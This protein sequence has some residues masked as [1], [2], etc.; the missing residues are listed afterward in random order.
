MAVFGNPSTNTWTCGLTWKWKG[1]LLLTP[2]YV[3][4]APKFLLRNKIATDMPTL[5]TILHLISL[6]INMMNR[7]RTK[8]CRQ[9]LILLKRSPPKSP[10]FSPPK[11]PPIT[12]EREIPPFDQ[13]EV[14]ESS[15][16]DTKKKQSRL[17]R[18]IPKI[19]LHLDYSRNATE[20]VLKKHRRGLK[21]NQK[22]AVKFVY[23]YFD[24]MLDEDGFITSL[25]NGVGYKP[26]RL[27]QI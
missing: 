6:M 21:E 8:P 22:E 17:Q 14:V 20:S 2:K 10:K 19:K 12:Q 11:F 9:W 4:S 27:K 25:A 26:C 3:P 15:R 5:S 23:D 16:L 18:T 1:T 13:K 7:S 24:D